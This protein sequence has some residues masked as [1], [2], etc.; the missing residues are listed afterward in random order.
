VS[1]ELAKAG[2]PGALERVAGFRRRSMAFVRA[3][4]AE[5]ERAGLLAPALRA[6]EASVVVLGSILALAHSPAAPGREAIPVLAPRVWAALEHLLRG[7]P[8]RPQSAGSRPPRP[9][10]RIA[11]RGR[12]R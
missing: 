3:C 1:E 2:S 9:T 6:E 8:T 11:R 4:L 12:P 5:A 7:S 10:G